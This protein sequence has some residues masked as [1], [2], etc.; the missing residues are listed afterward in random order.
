VI[1]FIAENKE[2][3]TQGLRWGFEPICAGLQISPA[4]VRSAMARPP[5]ARA[6]ADAA[7]KIRVRQVFDENYQV[8]GVRKIRAVL[9]RQGIR[10]AKNRVARLMRELDIRGATRGRTVR[11]TRP[12]ASHVRA[13][14]LVK[15]D[16]TACGPNRLWV[17]DF[18]YVPSWAG[19]VYV[20]FVIDVFSRMIVGWSLSTNMRTD[21]VMHALEHAIWRRDTLLD[22]LV[23]HSDAGSQY[24]SIRYTDRLVDIGARPSIGTVGDSYDNALAET[25]IGLYKTELVWRQAPWRTAEEL[26]LATLLY[27]EWFNTRRIHSELADRTPQEHEQIHYRQSRQPT[28]V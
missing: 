21:L 1:A 10:V 6:I 12:D 18:T 3:R 23:A 2:R 14:D 28:S 25:T 20:A 17:T 11:T 16:F 7:L 9:A 5:C 13:P 15:R 24:T 27:I 19:M 26:E 8:Y 22:G 4:T